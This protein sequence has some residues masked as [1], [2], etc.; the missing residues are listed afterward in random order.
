V[1]LDGALHWAHIRGRQG[2][3]KSRGERGIDRERESERG[4]RWGAHLGDHHLVLD[5]RGTTDIQSVH[6]SPS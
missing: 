5:A 4:G 2:S 3:D 1:S 6:E